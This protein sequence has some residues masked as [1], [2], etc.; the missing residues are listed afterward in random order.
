MAQAQPKAEPLLLR[1]N[2]TMPPDL[3]RRLDALADQ[4]GVSRSAIVH[5][6]LD[7][8]VTRE[9]HGDAVAE[10][11]RAKRIVLEQLSA[12]SVEEAFAVHAGISHEQACR[13]FNNTMTQ[14]EADELNRRAEQREREQG[15]PP[16]TFGRI[17]APRRAA[18]KGRHRE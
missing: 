12:M 10:A 2:T 15:L 3:L 17:A 7:E 9:E 18:G 5:H 14:E 8:A 16:Q 11:V 13:F 6:L 1:V 4:R